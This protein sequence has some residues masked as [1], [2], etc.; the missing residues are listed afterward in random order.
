MHFIVIMITCIYFVSIPSM[1]LHG[2]QCSICLVWV[3]Q[4]QQKGSEGHSTTN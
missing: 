2:F 1:S 3:L 4:S